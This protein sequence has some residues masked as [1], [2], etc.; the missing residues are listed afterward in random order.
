MSRSRG[1]PWAARE[2]ES[3]MS[4][5][6][7]RS[8]VEGALGLVGGLS[9]FPATNASAAQASALPLASA[10]AAEPQATREWFDLDL[11]TDEV[12]NSQLLHFLGATYSAQADIG[13]VLDTGTRINP[14]DEWSWP[15]EWVRTADRLCEMAEVSLARRHRLS[16]GNAYLRAANYYRAALIHHPDPTDPSVLATSRRSVEAYEKAIRLLEIPARPVRIPYG[17]TTLPGYF[18]RSP[19][20]RGSAP[21]FIFQQGRD[22]WPEESK[23]VIDGALER[24]YHCLIVHAPG[25]GMALREQ[26][27]SFRPDWESVV[28]PVVDFGLRISGV[29]RRRIA[30]L[31]WSMGGALVPRAAAFERRIKLLIPN[32]GVLNWGAASFASFDRFLPG[33]LPLL[34]EDPAA[35][36]ATIYQV[37][38]VVPLIRWYV[39]DAMAKHG[40]TSPSELMFELR[41]YDNEPT[42]D[43]ITAR[44]LVMDGTGEAF[45]VGEAKKLYDALRCPKDYL[46]FDAEDTGL[47]HCQ[48]AASAVAN[49]R[50]FDWVDEYI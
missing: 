42:V 29:D 40:V 14:A 34:D 45:S 11:M 4:S 32:P 20:A 37:M 47:L 36:D 17:R 19:S 6:P 15:L 27:L 26:G 31:G 33:V 8:L 10:G 24:G 18:F 21:L 38:E 43:R 25:Q 2:G 23:Y 22:A 49:H 41:A 13:E 7:R 48:E 30:L 16:A 9:L 1:P 39:R 12:M 5:I 44:T 46:L 3:S 35:F 50:M 28:S